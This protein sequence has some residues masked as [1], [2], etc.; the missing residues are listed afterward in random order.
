MKKYT[1]LFGFLFCL[2]SLAWAQDDG[3]LDEGYGPKAGDVTVEMQFGRANILTEGLMLP[4]A[5]GNAG[6]NWRV[7]ANSPFAEMIDLDGNQWSNMVGVKGRY[8]VSDNIATVLAGALRMDFTPGQTNVPGFIGG[9]S[10]AG[11]IPAYAAIPEQSSTLMTAVIGGEYTFNTEIRRVFPYLGVHVPFYYARNSEFDPT[12]NDGANVQDPNLI[13]DLGT[14]TAEVFGF[15]A[16][17]VGGV[18]FYAMEGLY[19]GF[20]I[21]PVSYIYAY[22][23]SKPGPGLELQQSNTN[24]YSFFTQPFLKFGFKF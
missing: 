23:A 16:Q 4:G 5:P 9:N 22:S 15:G 10:N 17:I 21:R 19:F 7:A 2:V 3:E 1:L 18:D 6:G 13:V 24:T 8:Y 14:R 12:V 11:W 20:E